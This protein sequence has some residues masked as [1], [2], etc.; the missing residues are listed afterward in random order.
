MSVRRAFAYA[1]VL[2]L[3][4]LVGVLP[5]RAERPRVAV[6]G[7]PDLAKA[8]VRAIAGKVEVV[9]VGDGAAARGPAELAREHQLN[10]V[11]VLSVPKRNRARAVVHDGATG[12]ELARHEVRV[13]ARL[14]ARR[15]AAQLWSKVGTKILSARAPAPPPPEP[16]PPPPE[17]AAAPPAATPRPRDDA[18]RVTATARVRR[19]THAAPRF[20]LAVEERPFWR[21][22]RYNDDLE[23]RLRPFD[24]VANAV[25]VSARV[26]PVSTA[27]GLSLVARGE[28]AIGLHGSRTSDGMELPTTSSEWSLGAGY[29]LGLGPVRAGLQ[30]AYGEHRFHVGDPAMG[31]E[32][33]PDVSYRWARAGVTYEHRLDRRWTLAV[34]GG[35]RHLLSLGGLATSAWFPRATGGGLDAG[36][37]LSLQLTSWLAV[38]ARLDVRRYFFAMN[39]EPGDPWIAGG[40]IDQYL[41]A[42]LGATV[43][44]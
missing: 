10:A 3:V 33:V 44:R 31:A 6:V 30:L 9:E 17:V 32:L 39:P 18:A 35:W 22:L 15:M 37:G 20:A 12:A 40:A 5:A 1:A 26:R 42:A 28:R 23:R 41:G 2:A 13:S 24:L 11:I 25:A 38:H 4:W 27:R 36:A 21:R 7:A 19:S 29:D 16:P 8:V 43:A 14:L 34:A